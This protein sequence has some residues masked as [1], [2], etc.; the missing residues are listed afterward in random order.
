MSILEHVITVHDRDE[1]LHEL[2][3]LSA[4]SDSATIRKMVSESTSS[5]KSLL[6]SL[7]EG[8]D[9]RSNLSNAISE[10][11]SVTELQLTAVR[12][13]PPEVL[14]KIKDWFVTHVGKQTVLEISYDPSLIAGI[15]ITYNGKYFDGSVSEAVAD[16]MTESKMRSLLFKS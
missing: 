4:N 11:R 13:L 14:S 8:D 6:L 15:Q 10:L 7:C 2:E 9:V 3:L 1:V 12:K 16:Y 5:H